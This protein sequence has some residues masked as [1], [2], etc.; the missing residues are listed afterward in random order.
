MNLIAKSTQVTFA[1]KD[2]I[3]YA[4][5]RCEKSMFGNNVYDY[6]DV[7]F[8]IVHGT[9]VEDGTIQGFLKMFN[10][11]YC[12]SDI[13]ASAVGM[14]KYFCKCILKDND[15]PTLDC[16]CFTYDDTMRE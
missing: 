1:P 5:I 10:I 2:E 8:P 15:I 4:L 9:N 13:Y 12:E 11:P 3:K 16:K 7:A 6:I 14:D